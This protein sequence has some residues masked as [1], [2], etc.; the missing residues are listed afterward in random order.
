MPTLSDKIDTKK[1]LVTIILPAYNEE[2]ILEKNVSLLYDY[3]STLDNLYN[4]EVLIINDGSTDSTKTI[5]DSLADTKNNLRSYHH[6]VNRNLGTALRTGFKHSKGKYVIVLD[7][8]MSYSPDH[9]EKLL[10]KLVSA[11]ADMVIASPYMKGGKNTAVPRLRL[12]LSKTVNYMMRKSSRLNIYTFTG[13]VRAY[14]GNFIRSLNTKSSTFDINSEIIL[15]AYILRARVIEIPAH[16]DWSEQIKLGKI[17]TSSLRIVKG[18]FNGLANSFMFRP[19]M[20]F[21]I[22]GLVIFILSIYII[23]WIFINTYSAY[24][25]TAE[26]AQGFEDRFSLAVSEVFRQR[27]YSF[28]VGGTTMI[29]SLQLLGLG[30][31]SLQKKRYFDELFHLNSAILKATKKKGKSTK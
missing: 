24:P 21:W 5:A 11:Q 15:K 26:L 9:I 3:L 20:F 25:M 27:P 29:I 1:P 4:W 6:I 13:M 2:A 10:S 12:L 19:Y 31:I 17:R 16:L 28:I 22:L 30:F 23:I 8:D 18:I 14:K 7:I